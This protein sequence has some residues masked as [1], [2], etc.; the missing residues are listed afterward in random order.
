MRPPGLLLLPP[1]RSRDRGGVTVRAL[2]DACYSERFMLSGF[3]KFFQT[4]YGVAI[5]LAFL[6]LIGFAFAASDMLGTATFGGVA[7]GNRVAVVEDEKIGSAELEQAA[8]NALRQA[9]A[10]NPTLTIEGFI[11]QGGLEDVLESLITRS[12]IAQFAERYGSRAGDNLINS[13]IRRLPAF[14]GPD[15][16]FDEDAYRQALAQAGLSDADF[17]AD[18]RA[19]LLAQQTFSAASFGA[20]MPAALARRYGGLLGERRR[21][22]IALLDSARFAP[23]GD[24]SASALQSYYR[25][26]RGAYIRPERRV[27][28]YAVL[29]AD[30]VAGRIAPTEA[31]LR[32][33]YQREAERFAA[34]ERR[35]TTQIIVPTEAAARSIAERVRGGG[36]LEAA[37]REAGFE[38]NTTGPIDLEELRD[39]TSAA[40]ARAVFD[41]PQGAIAQPARSGLG[42]HVVRVDSIA[43]RDARSFASARGELEEELREEKRRQALNE[44]ATEIDDRLQDGASLADIARG[45]DLDVATTRPLTADG[46][47]YGR[48]EQAPELLGSLLPTAFEVGE[49]DPQLAEAVR[50]ETFVLFEAARVEPAATA[51]LREIRDRVIADW[52]RDRGAR[53]ARQAAARVIERVRGGASLQAAL[54]ENGRVLGTSETVNL[55]REELAQQGQLPAP[56]QLM[57][58]MAQGTAKPLALPR[59]RGWYVV[60]LDEIEPGTLDTAS[61]EGRA[62]LEAIRN[63]L[64]QAVGQEYLEQLS[65]AIV[66]RSNIERNEQAI[67]AVRQRLLGN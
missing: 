38:P 27:L 9:Q 17:R 52:R 23:E 51:P 55:S 21:G 8:R 43:R 57:F 28:R 12:A 24:P 16:N 32:A 66:A 11:A 63:A 29:D 13:E 56:M 25:E 36:S 44:F 54:R 60:A 34:A 58:S 26:N 47:V 50:G 42:W 31:E 61:D 62:R 5:T 40:V 15:G 53:A 6:V 45:L 18:A 3:R 20:T 49:G 7:G 30:A 65:E 41:A 48:D 1:R 64:G 39:D 22:A 14:R 35:G 37:A 33:R 19:G 4:R 10:E 2:V 46:R 59:N 67:E